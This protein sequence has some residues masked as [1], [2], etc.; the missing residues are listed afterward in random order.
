[1][2]KWLIAL[3]SMFFFLGAMSE[4]WTEEKEIKVYHEI[5]TP[6]IEFKNGQ[7]GENNG[8]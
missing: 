2:D 6:W 5:D 8:K 3:A 4:I 7:I 1:M